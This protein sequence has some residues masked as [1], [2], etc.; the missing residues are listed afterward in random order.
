MESSPATKAI[1][2]RIIATKNI[3]A[4]PVERNANPDSLSRTALDNYRPDEAVLVWV[5]ELLKQVRHSSGGKRILRL[6][7]IVWLRW[8]VAFK[9]MEMILAP[10]KCFLL[11][12]IWCRMMLPPVPS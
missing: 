5:K 6:L 1:A 12:I 10:R 3:A 8:D 11:L 7:L 4:T 2:A 9:W